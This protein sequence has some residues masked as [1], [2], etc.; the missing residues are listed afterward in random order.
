LIENE[1]K[2]NPFD[3][4]EDQGS[5]KENPLLKGC[6]VKIPNLDLFDEKIKELKSK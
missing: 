6:R 3:T 2:E 1:P 4:E 5:A